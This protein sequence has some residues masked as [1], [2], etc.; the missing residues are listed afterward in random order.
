MNKEEIAIFIGNLLI[1]ITCPYLFLLF[2]N[3]FK[4]LCG[5]EDQE[6]K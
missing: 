5:I 1:S 2:D 4:V 6:D 3:P